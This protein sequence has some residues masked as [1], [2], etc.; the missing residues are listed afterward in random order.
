MND[1]QKLGVALIIFC[2]VMWFYAIPYHVVGKTPKLFPRL[3]VIFTLIPGILLVI[4]RKDRVREPSLLFKDQV[5]IHKAMITA[6]L[7]LGYISLIDITGYFVSSFIAIMVFL[8][9]FG[10]RNWTLIVLIPAVILFFIYVVIEK[11]LSFPLPKG[12]VY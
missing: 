10:S 8:Y 5:G 6:V 9:F 11:M 2:T 3:I 1:D 12:L 4:T 7:F